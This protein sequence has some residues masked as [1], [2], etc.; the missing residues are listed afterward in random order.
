M[1]TSSTFG[2]ILQTPKIMWDADTGNSEDYA[3]ISFASFD[4]LDAAVEAMKGSISVTTQSLC[5]MASKRTPSVSTVA[6]YPNNF[7]QPR[8]HFPRLTAFISCW[9]MHPTLLTPTP[10]PN[11]VV[12]S[13]GPGLPPPGMPLPQSL[14]PPLLPPGALPPG[15]PPTIPSPP[16]L[17]G[18]GGQGPPSART[19]EA[20]HPGYRHSY[21]HPFPPGGMPHPGMSQM[22]LAHHTLMA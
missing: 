2:V 16:M 11:S 22:Q 15:I 13:L 5:S 10:P 6:Q 8:T 1:I 14:P 19:P 12:S 20:G 3:V 17:P 4:A 9:Q 7:W 21:P 18:A